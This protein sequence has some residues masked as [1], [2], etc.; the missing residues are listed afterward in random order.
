[1]VAVFNPW[2]FELSSQ[3]FV[4]QIMWSSLPFLIVVFVMQLD[5]AFDICCGVIGVF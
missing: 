3:G 4:S 2:Y 1:M 5:V